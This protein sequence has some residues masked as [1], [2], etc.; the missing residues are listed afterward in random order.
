MLV[1]DVSG[2]FIWLCTMQA[3]GLENRFHHLY[4]LAP[5]TEECKRRFFK[6]FWFVLAAFCLNYVTANWKQ[7][8]FSCYV[9][10]SRHWRQSRFLLGLP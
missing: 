2:K 4:K 10:V 9:T 5:G 1:R 8:F 3:G 6:I 7:V